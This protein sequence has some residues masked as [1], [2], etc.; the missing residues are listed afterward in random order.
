M[1]QPVRRVLTVQTVRL[2]RLERLELLDR[3]ERRVIQAQQVIPARQE[4]RFTMAPT[5]PP[6]LLLPHLLAELAITILIQPTD[7]ST[8]ERLN[9]YR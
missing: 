1:A 7:T 6:Y 5:P 3:L 4:R 8:S 2:E 9:R